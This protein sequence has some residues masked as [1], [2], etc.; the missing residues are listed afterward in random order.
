MERHSEAYYKLW[1]DPLINQAEGVFYRLQLKN[2]DNHKAV[3]RLTPQD[4]GEDV[5]NTI[6]KVLGEVTPLDLV[7]KFALDYLTPEE[8]EEE[9]ENLPDELFQM[10]KI[11]QQAKKIPSG[12]YDRQAPYEG[13][14]DM[15]VLLAS[16]NQQAIR[17]ALCEAAT[18]PS[19]ARR[20]L[21][22]MGDDLVY[23]ESMGKTLRLMAEHKVWRILP[24]QAIDGYI[25]C[26]KNSA[27]HSYRIL[28][29]EGCA[30]M[31]ADFETQRAID[32]NYTPAAPSAPITI[33]PAVRGNYRL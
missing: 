23:L 25:K 26:F 17:H 18:I 10:L 21:H 2:A 14:I 1:N 30:K 7:C 8:L 12:A 16:Q 20:R 15:S 22:E 19:G 4:V 32:K 27:A 6:E 31:I 29:Q 24:P 13:I 33:R 28:L 9:K 5:V 3:Y 11:Q